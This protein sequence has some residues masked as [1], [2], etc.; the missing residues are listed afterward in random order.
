MEER[1]VAQSLVICNIKIRNP[2]YTDLFLLRV[3][4]AVHCASES[5]ASVKL[6]QEL[7]CRAAGSTFTQKEETNL[8]GSKSRMDLPSTE[9]EP[10]GIL[11]I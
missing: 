6:Q 3:A 10:C 7:D 9:H 2:K 8:H 4:I 1:K 11:Q 5:P